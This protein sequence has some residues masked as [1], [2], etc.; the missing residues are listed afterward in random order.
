MSPGW[1]LDN[2]QLKKKWWSWWEVAGDRYLHPNLEE[3]NITPSAPELKIWLGK[4]V[5]WGEK[6]IPGEKK[7]LWPGSVI[8]P[9]EKFFLGQ[10]FA[11]CSVV[12]RLRLSL[13]G[14]MCLCWC[15]YCLKFNKAGPKGTCLRGEKKKYWQGDIRVIKSQ[16]FDCHTNF[17]SRFTSMHRSSSCCCFF[18]G[19]HPARP[20]LPAD[21]LKLDK[22]RTSSAVP[23]LKEKKKFPISP[24]R[25]V[26]Y[27]FWFH[28]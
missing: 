8:W 7:S 3:V 16:Q 26:I 1:D 20:P 27:S 21:C 18:L 12:S 19:Q 10:T 28:F 6:T 5:T 2:W 17:H 15:H 25:M 11:L 23:P 13:P 9:H 14:C 24:T 4:S 22:E